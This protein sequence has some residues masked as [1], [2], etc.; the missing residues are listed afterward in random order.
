MARISQLTARKADTNARAVIH[1]L[2]A[3]LVAIGLFVW[4]SAMQANTMP[5]SVLSQVAGVVLAA[6]ILSVGWQLLGRRRFADELMATAHLSADVVNSGIARV[7]DLYLQEVEWDELFDGVTNLDI[8]VAYGRTWRHTHEKQLTD[9]ARRPDSTVRVFLPDPE[10]EQTMSVLAKRFSVAAQ[11]LKQ[12][13]EE[14]IQEF[15]GLAVAGGGA[16]EV[17]VR[18]GDAVFSCY[19]FDQR[20]VLT[21][22]SHAQRRTSVP[23]FSLKEGTLFAFLRRELDAVLEQSR[24]VFP[25]TQPQGGETS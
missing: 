10:D 25:R 5:Q 1:G 20:A 9:V 7:T 2:V 16:V 17:Y 19:R 15:S 18:A 4:S 6:G 23:T 22:Y 11:D 13:V 21:L 12:T 24:L 14:A 8:M 3:L